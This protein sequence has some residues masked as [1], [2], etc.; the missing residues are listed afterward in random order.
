MG[1]DI[2]R[3]NMIVNKIKL[4]ALFSYIKFLSDIASSLRN[5]KT[6]LWVPAL[7]GDFVNLWW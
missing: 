4:F 2:I 1:Q 7:T 6:V 3:N 5:L